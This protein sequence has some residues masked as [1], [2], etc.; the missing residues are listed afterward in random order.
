MMKKF[1]IIILTLFLYVALLNNIAA[2]NI[3]MTDIQSI[4]VENDKIINAIFKFKPLDITNHRKIFFYFSNKDEKLNIYD[5]NSLLYPPFCSLDFKAFK[6]GIIHIKQFYDVDNDIIFFGITNNNYL[7][8]DKYNYLISIN[9]N[10]NYNILCSPYT[11]N[12]LYNK[13]KPSIPMFMIYDNH[14]SLELVNLAGK[15]SQKYVYIFNYDKNNNKFNIID[16]GLIYF[17][18]D[19]L[20]K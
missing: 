2:A 18:F 13:N 4:N 6:G 9:K 15:H 3:I 20:K 19:E 7:F 8:F 16:K 17:N 10:T 1:K 14:I 5:N 11:F 12:D